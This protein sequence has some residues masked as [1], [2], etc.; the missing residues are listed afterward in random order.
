MASINDRF[1]QASVKP[2]Q[3]FFFSGFLFRRSFLRKPTAVDTWQDL[4]QRTS[5]RHGSLLGC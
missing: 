4:Q 3:A 1:T 2:S 5:K